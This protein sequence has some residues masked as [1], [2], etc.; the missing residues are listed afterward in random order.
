MKKII[1]SLLA[2][3]VLVASFGCE[4]DQTVTKFNP[5]N[6]DPAAAYFAQKTLSEEFPASTTGD[7]TLLVDVYRHNA[8][9]ELTVG[10]DRSIPAE[11]APF[12]E[13]PSTITFPDGEYHVAIPVK[14][15]GVDNFAKGSIYTATILVGDD[16]AFTELAPAT[17]KAPKGD[18]K[19][20]ATRSLDIAAE[21]TS[22]TLSTT[23]TLEWEPAYILQDPSKL[24][25][26][27]LTDADY[28]VG[29]DGKPMPQTADFIYNGLWSGD[30][31]SVVI[32]RAKGTTVF[33]MT[34]WG[35]GEHN[36][37]FTV[38]PDKKITVDGKQYNTVTVTEQVVMIHDSYGD[39]FV[40]DIP[41]YTGG[42]QSYDAYPCYWD[43][44]RGFHLELYYYVSAGAFNTPGSVEMLTFHSGIA[45]IEDPE[46]AV[47]I[48]YKGLS[49]T[50]T[51]IRNHSLS[52]TPNA[53]AAYY[54]ATVL[55]ENLED[56]DAPDPDPDL[57]AAVTEEFLAENGI[58]KDNPNWDA[59]Y[60]RYYPQIEAELKA[61]IY[62]EML[63]EALETRLP[64]I[65]EQI[66]KG[67][68]EGDTPAVKYTEPS[69]DVWELGSEGGLF[70]AVAFSYDRSGK[71][72]GIDYKVFLYNPDSDASLVEYELYAVADTDPSQGLFAYNSIYFGLQALNGDITRVSYALLTKADF[73]KAAL[74]GAADKQLQEYL[75]ANGKSLNAA[76]LEAANG[77][78]GYGSFLTADAA[79]E[80]RLV[81]AV[82][83]ADATKY[84]VSSVTTEAVAAPTKIACN[85]MVT[86]QIKGF[87]SHTH[88]IGT[89]AGKEVVGGYY[90]MQDTTKLRD[91]LTVD[92]AGK[93]VLADEVTD[94]DMIALIEGSGSAFSSGDEDSD[95]YALNTGDSA[96]APFKAKPAT[97]YVVLACATYG[98]GEK[99]WSAASVRTAYAPSVAFTQT[100]QAAG[101]NISFT[102]SATPQAAI[103]RVS[104]V[105]YALVPKAALTQA[106]VNLSLLADEE[107]NDFDARL[108][109]G[110]PAADIEA[111]RKNAALVTGI[112][113]AEGK[114][115]QGDMAGSINSAEGFSRQ[116]PN[117]AAGDYALIALAYDSYNTKLTVAQITV[118]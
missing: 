90:M 14:I 71:F 74:E 53:D 79:T 51:E 68:Y 76:A 58:G 33:R 78:D 20:A 86:D 67:T 50:P 28:V 102:W 55:K 44:D 39:V 37:I 52:F 36:V 48:D 105:V 114:T 59:I 85:P 7:Q 97:T 87:Y 22:I 43:G 27:D 104:K 23:I 99:S 64:A 70:T 11:S 21:Y 10:L 34:N 72:K 46:P 65:R 56:I 82:S 88:V 62:E 15:K 111:Q 117:V 38:N 77:E 112:L 6:G 63:Q 35:D 9:G 118:Q 81:T 13:I 93:V 54:Y 80:Y 110:T 3:G 31:N 17:L 113:A 25:S 96:M 8:Q 115:V 60:G 109:A 75:A 73:E 24:L 116:F 41:S 32:E 98:N 18:R 108:A 4:K 84:E 83:N 69:T 66:E 91:Y 107:L 49:I 29:P 106:G 42:G 47:E 92:A 19:S 1:K 16:H 12:Y 30:D 89:F 101:R 61:Q 2:V 94:D 26:T 45:Q 103:F 40:S 5:E 95:L 100:A 57:V